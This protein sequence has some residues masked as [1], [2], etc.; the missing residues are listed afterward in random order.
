MVRERM[1]ICCPSVSFNIVAADTKI[2]K[3]YN[4]MAVIPGHIADEV[5]MVGNHRDGER[6]AFAA[7]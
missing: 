3:I 6:V 2:T 4:T 5:V 7:Q 1:F